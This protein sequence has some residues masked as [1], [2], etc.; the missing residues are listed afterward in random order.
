MPSDVN[1]T[2]DDIVAGPDEHA[3][4]APA[5]QSPQDDPQPPPPSPG[6]E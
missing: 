3:A 4:P 2:A 6:T 1:V 5:A